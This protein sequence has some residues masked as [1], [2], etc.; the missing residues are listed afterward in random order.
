MPTVAEPRPR[1]APRRWPKRLLLAFLVLALLAGVF[2]VSF[3]YPRQ[4]V[5]GPKIQGVPLCAWQEHFRDHVARKEP[6]FAERR[7]EPSVLRDLFGW[8]GGG[9]SNLKWDS[10]RE[11]ERDTVLLSLLDDPQPYVRAAVAGS[12][13]AANSPKGVSALL[14]LW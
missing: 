11:S 14:Q 5:F 1:P 4:L 2:V 13:F 12:F 10:L 6:R 9:G 7:Q 8:L 3:P